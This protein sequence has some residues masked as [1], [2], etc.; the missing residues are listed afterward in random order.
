MTWTDSAGATWPDNVACIEYVQDGRYY[1]ENR[2]GTVLE[3]TH[4]PGQPFRPKV[5]SP[6]SGKDVR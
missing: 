3:L 2:D 6:P 5:V 4:E 1:R